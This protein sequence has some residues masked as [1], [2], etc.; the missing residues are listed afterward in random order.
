MFGSFF[1]NLI[2]NNEV[3][4]PGQERN[5]KSLLKY[6][7]SHGKD[8]F[9]S[10]VVIGSPPGI[11]Y[12]SSGAGATGRKPIHPTLILAALYIHMWLSWGGSAQ[13]TSSLNKMETCRSGIA[14]TEIVGRNGSLH[15]MLVHS[16]RVERLLLEIVNQSPDER[17]A[18]LSLYPLSAPL[19]WASIEW[20]L[21][22]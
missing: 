21:K 1:S 9:D 16:A 14:L 8:L 18:V 22:K 13:L 7:G 2:G 12:Y 4:N 11:D 6:L 20:V 19:A 17:L 10:I 5:A 3:G 15:E